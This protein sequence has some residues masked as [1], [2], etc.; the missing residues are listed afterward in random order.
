MSS[1]C[2]FVVDSFADEIA[3]VHRQ[4]PAE[5]FKFLEPRLIENCDV[6]EFILGAVTRSTVQI[7]HQCSSEYAVEEFVECLFKHAGV[8]P[9][10]CCT[11]CHVSYSSY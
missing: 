6:A 5:P 4:F 7:A 8:E 10:L 9:R 2:V 3:T 11:V 1:N